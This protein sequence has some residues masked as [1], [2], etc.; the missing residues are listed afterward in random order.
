MLKSSETVYML[1]SLTIVIVEAN[2]VDQYQKQ[3][4][5][6]CMCLHCLTQ[7]LLKHLVD[8]KI[9]RLCCNKRLQDYIN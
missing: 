9:R 6:Q 3:S 4:I 2:S 1:I 5:T 8:D 7:R